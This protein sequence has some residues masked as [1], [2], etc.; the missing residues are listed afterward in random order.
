MLKYHRSWHSLGLAWS[1]I[2]MVGRFN[3]STIKNQ[4]SPSKAAG[5]LKWVQDTWLKSEGNTMLLCKYLFWQWGPKGQNYFG[6]QL[7]L[8]QD[9]LLNAK[10]F[11]LQSAKLKS[12]WCLGLK[13]ATTK[14]S[15]K[16]SL[17][18]DNKWENRTKSTCCHVHS[19][20]FGCHS[21]YASFLMRRI[22]SHSEAL[23]SS[24][25]SL[26]NSSVF[27]LGK[28]RAHFCLKLQQMVLLPPAEMP[29][30]SMLIYY[31]LSFYWWSVSETTLW[32]S[33]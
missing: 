29:L 11:C 32:E 9:N 15:Q 14:P 27:L 21:Y 26:A 4:F 7:S 5:Q 1:N 10:V 25:L 6:V 20:V 12:L 17:K 31:A 33:L 16:M 23:S 28:P 19:Y 8:L 3:F 30:L 22:C 18:W 13:S 2:F 24:M